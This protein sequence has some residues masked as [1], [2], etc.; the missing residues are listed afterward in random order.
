MKTSK[1]RQVGMTFS[2]PMSVTRTGG[3]VVHIL[4]LPSDSTTQTVPVSAT[5]KFAPEMPT[6]A[7]RNFS[8][9]YRRAASVRSEGLSERFFAPSLPDKELPDLRAVL[10]DRR[11]QDVRARSP[12]RAG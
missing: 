1:S 12:R 3:S 10:V 9:R 7:A 2:I 8:R 5:A 11:H 4:P 6:F